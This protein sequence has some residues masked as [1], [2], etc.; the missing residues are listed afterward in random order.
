[1]CLNGSGKTTAKLRYKSSQAV[2]CMFTC[3]LRI[4]QHNELK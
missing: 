3:M 1:V 4:Y 2:A